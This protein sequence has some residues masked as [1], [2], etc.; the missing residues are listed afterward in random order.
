MVYRPVRNVL[1]DGSSPNICRDCVF[2][3]LMYVFPPIPEKESGYFLSKISGCGTF[4]ICKECRRIRWTNNT[5]IAK[6]ADYCKCL[7]GENK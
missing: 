5:E 6:T 7:G 4:H 2:A 1:G 3:V